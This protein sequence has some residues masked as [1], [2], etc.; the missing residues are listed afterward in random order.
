MNYREALQYILGFTDYERLSAAAY[1]AADFDLRRVE[2]LLHRLGDPHLEPRTIH[3]AG[4]KGKGSTAAMIA[5]ALTAAGHRT[6][7]YTSPHLHTLR[8]RIKIDGETISEDELPAIVDSIKPHIEETNHEARYGRLTTFEVLTAI[9]FVFFKQRNVDFQVLETGLG[10]RLDATNVARPEICIITPVSTDHAD[11]LGQT[12]GEIALEKAGIIKA[13]A[14]VIIAPQPSAA[15]EILSEAVA[16]HGDRIIH[17]GRTM[18]WNKLSSGLGGQEFEL[19]SGK[20]VY[21]LSIPLL[22]RHQLENAAVAVAA[23]ESLDI[24]VGPIAEG[25]LKVRWPGRLE[26]L[27]REPLLLVD[28]AHNPESARR[29]R[30]AIQEYIDYDRSVLIVGVS[31]DKDIAGILHELAPIA[32]S[33]IVTHSRHPRAMPSEQ[34]L[35]AVNKIGLHATTSNGVIDAIERALSAAGSRDLICVTGS[36]FVAAEAIEHVRG[37]P[38]DVIV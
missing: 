23:L 25:L 7:L 37:V 6:G 14:L 5:S 35:E 15:E 22:G 36:L 9:A 38:R 4:T 20:G 17:A 30:E 2:E 12:I 24:D 8:E 33:I 21:R 11:I 10:G 34:A 26:I 32:G 27:R 18:T 31:C 13:G 1:A 16:S 3:I 19:T 28:G 29:L